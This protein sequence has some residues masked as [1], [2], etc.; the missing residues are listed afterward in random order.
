MAALGQD[1]PTS[2]EE[3]AVHL[4]HPDKEEAPPPY[5]RHS[6]EDLLR[7]GTQLDISAEQEGPEK[8]KSI[9][10]RL[11]IS[12]LLSTWNSRVFEFA[13]L[14]FIGHLWKDTLLPVSIYALV[15]SASA[16]CFAPM[17]GRYVDRGDRLRTVRLSIGMSNSPPN[18]YEY[19]RLH[20]LIVSQSV[21]GL[22]CFC[23]S[24]ALFSLNT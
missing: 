13:C 5:T 8:E 4:L 2:D 10:R 12:H 3:E 6:T 19:Q 14:L 17:V 22:Q 11:Y 18:F 15:R 1:S 24:E 20:Q 23:G 9:K 16:I 7:T 21:N